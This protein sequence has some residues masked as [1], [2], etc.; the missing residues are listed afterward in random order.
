MNPRWIRPSVVTSEET[1]VEA[2]ATLEQAEQL[3]RALDE[4]RERTGTG[5]I[6]DSSVWENIAMA[7]PRSCKLMSKGVRRYGWLPTHQRAPTTAARHSRRPGRC[8]RH[9]HR[10]RGR[11]LCTR[12]R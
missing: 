4:L 6:A 11:D 5:F 10:L 7:L 9:R 1:G 3:R 12:A 8:L 2:R